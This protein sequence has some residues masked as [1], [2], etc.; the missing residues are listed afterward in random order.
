ML[1]FGSGASKKFNICVD[2]YEGLT[3]VKIRL[4]VRLSSDFLA[5]ARLL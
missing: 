4:A 5:M 3:I 2:Y 1:Y